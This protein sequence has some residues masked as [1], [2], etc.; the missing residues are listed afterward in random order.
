MPHNTVISILILIAIAF[1]LAGWIMVVIALIQF[2]MG[3]Y[4][5]RRNFFMKF[6]GFIFVGVLLVALGIVS[7]KLGWFDTVVNWFG[8]LIK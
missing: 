2:G 3:T 8:G 1:L 5:K 6:L 7:V 4:F